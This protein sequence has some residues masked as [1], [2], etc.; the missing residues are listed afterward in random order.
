MREANGISIRHGG[1]ALLVT[2]LL[3]GSLVGCAGSAP[4][5]TI[6]SAT[7]TTS[8]GT[9]PTDSASDEATPLAT[10]LATDA[11]S[12]TPM[13]GSTVLPPNAGDTTTS[14]V[15]AAGATVEAAGATLV[16]PSGA[17]SGD[18]EV[19]IA[20][21][22]APYH[23]NVFA[24]ADPAA[25]GAIPVSAPY[26]FG[27][28][29]VTF[30]TPVTVTLPYDPQYLPVDAGP[31][32]LSVVYFNGK[33][34]A[35]LGGTVDTTNHTMSVRL[36]SFDGILLA[37]AIGFGIGIPVMGVIYWWYGGEGTK[38][39][40]ISRKEA[41]KWINPTAPAVEAAAASAT[42]GGVPMNDK[43]RIGEYLKN[44]GASTTPVTFNGPDGKPM[45]LVNRYSDE[46][47]TNWQKPADFFDPAKGNLHGDC[48]DVTNAVVSM[49]R[50]LGY[51]AKGVFGYQVNTK[52]PHA[53]GEVLIGGKVYLIDEEG[54]LQD[55]DK[56]M[57]AL[58]LI[59]PEPGDPRLAMWDENSED[60][61]PLPP[62]TPW[63]KMVPS[64]FSLTGGSGI[65]PG[66]AD[67]EGNY[68]QTFS[69]VT[70]TATPNADEKTYTLLAD[71]P[72]I[73]I[74]WE[75]YP[76]DIVAGIGSFSMKGT[77]DPA[78]KAVTGTFVYKNQAEG[79]ITSSFEGELALKFSRIWQ[80]DVTGTITDGVAELYFSGDTQ[81]TCVMGGND[82]SD[83]GG[84]QGQRVWFTTATE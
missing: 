56:A 4:T 9:S 60:P 83:S 63:W 44:N 64:E 20:R 29:G 2:M 42:L 39:D 68:G 28:A 16:V 55:I 11:V 14:T 17:V 7:P 77:Y 78:T 66:I 18:T 34:W 82:C 25:V 35:A 51:P 8:A 70:I 10:D 30:A 52:H 57:E 5:S 62:E 23:I 46:A 54:K 67:T 21:L 37:V 32:D 6:P 79:M 71:D 75:W 36:Q 22:N 31:A 38:D 81:S 45:T 1:R 59:R 84:N 72:K 41:D 24:H 12:V 61:Y 13:L 19:S 47:S 26:D 15:T 69:R 33:T 27:P 40:A 65:G 53:W 80:G 73:L 48:T 74:S 50:K 3:S 49:F 76:G 43:E 58:K